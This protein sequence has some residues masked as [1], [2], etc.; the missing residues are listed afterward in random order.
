MSGRNEITT[1]ALLLRAVDYSE[2][3]KVVTLL[4]RDAGKLSA[5]AR[6]VRKST[7]RFRGGLG[8]LQPLEVVI[9]I[10]S[11]GLSSLRGSEAVVD[12]SSIGADLLRLGAGALVLELIDLTVAEG[13]GDASFYQ[14]CEGFVR[15][16]A[17]ETRGPAWIDA[18]VQR[19]QL[20]LMDQAGLLPDVE[21]SARDGRPA[22]R[23]DRPFWLR[24][25]GL[26]DGSERKLGEPGVALTPEG[27][28]HLVT[29]LHGRFAVHDSSAADEVR[30]LIA[31]I[32][33]WTL[34]RDPKAAEMYRTAWHAVV[35]SEQRRG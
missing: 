26:V 3:D 8:M 21:F 29:T 30:D 13:Q 11:E 5:F 16:L 20:L 32:W 25:G 2:A 7:R 31:H 9:A 18:G 35:S 27:L 33:R 24:D 34:D 17:A 10:R 14:R 6:G 23:I 4:T 15:W 22:S 12:C 1:P 19:M 28:E